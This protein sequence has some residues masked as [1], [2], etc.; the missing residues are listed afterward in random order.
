MNFKKFNM[1]Y[2][3]KQ[4][5]KVDYTSVNDPK[6]INLSYN[7]DANVICDAENSLL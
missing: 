5:C 3:L 6:G 7:D 4:C 2:E 1:S